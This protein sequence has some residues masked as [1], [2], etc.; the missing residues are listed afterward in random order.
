MKK[1]TM[2]FILAM[3]LVL[4]ATIGGTIAW[5]TDKTDTVT[6]TFTAGDID[7]TLAETTSAYK[8][9]PGCDIDKDPTVTVKAGSEACWLFV[10]VAKNNSPDNFLDYSINGSWTEL[11]AGSGVYYR[12][13]G[14]AST[15]QS[16]PVLNGNK[17]SVKRSVTKADLNAL[18]Q[19]TYPTLSFTAYAIQKE[20]FANAADAWTEVSRTSNP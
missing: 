3:V 13:V 7:I 9:I 2:A 12:S 16:F 17:V 18:T 10:K 19:A 5:L 14:A 4:G 6:N 15:D 20:G 1:R 11:T 8:M